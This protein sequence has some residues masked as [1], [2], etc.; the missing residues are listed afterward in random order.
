MNILIA[1]INLKIPAAK[2]YV[3]PAFESSMMEISKKRSTNIKKVKTIAE[4]EGA[5]L[6]DKFEVR[7]FSTDQFVCN[8]L[9]CLPNG[10]G[11]H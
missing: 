10:Y 11:I 2:K 4:K 3:V 6:R 1:I 7:F 8:T 9:G 5:F